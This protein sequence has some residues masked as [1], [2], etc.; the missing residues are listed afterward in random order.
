MSETRIA[1]IS[2]THIPDRAAELHPALI[3]ELENRQV[4]LIL[5]AGDISVP[6]IVD[7]LSEIAPVQAVRGNRDLFFPGRLPIAIEM[8]VNGVSLV[9]THGHLNFLTYAWDK[10][11]YLFRGYDRSRF[12]HRLAD[13]YPK[14]KVIIFGHSHRAE[15][16]W[17]DGR[18]FF[19]PGSAAIGDLWDR[20]CS[21]GLIEIHQDGE[22]KSQLVPLEG[23]RLI[24]R[25]W[26]PV[27]TRKK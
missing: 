4:D 16:L 12:I 13:A 19:N 1:I 24:R 17:V 25:K 3:G 15:N 27:Q 6:A 14:A 7:R 2:D 23:Y 8:E 22:I 26:R 5:H 18:L 9:L 21:F 11:Q 10:F 20:T